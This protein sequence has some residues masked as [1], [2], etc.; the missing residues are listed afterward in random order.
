[1]L[2]LP[3][4]P[5]LINTTN[6]ELLDQMMTPDECEKS[7][8]GAYMRFKMICCRRVIHLWMRIERRSQRVSD[9][10]LSSYHRF[11]EGYI[12]I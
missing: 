3:H 7:L 9:F 12:H 2:S 10:F 1:M 11:D 8:Y 4:Y 6:F 5:N